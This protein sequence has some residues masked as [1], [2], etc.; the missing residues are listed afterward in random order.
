MSMAI[1]FFRKNLLIESLL[2]DEIYEA[3]WPKIS[4]LFKGNSFFRQISA[5]GGFFAQR[6]QVITR[7]R[8][9]LDPKTSS[10]QNEN[11]QIRSGSWHASEKLVFKESS[12]ERLLADSKLGHDESS[13]FSDRGFGQSARIWLSPAPLINP[14]PR[15]SA[16]LTAMASSGS[17]SSFVPVQPSSSSSL[18]KSF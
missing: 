3:I 16:T 4:Y 1:I 15:C 6:F 11:D 18:L 10:A 9:F 7:I 5:V 13:T 17:T 8:T 12:L 2:D 14:S